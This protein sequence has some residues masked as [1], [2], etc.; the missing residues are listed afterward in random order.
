MARLRRSDCHDWPRS[1][2]QPVEG[3]V[4]AVLPLADTAAA[5]GRRRG[6]ADRAHLRALVRGARAGGRAHD[7]HLP[8]V[9]CGGHRHA[10]ARLPA[11]ARPERPVRVAA[12]PA[13]PARMAEMIAAPARSERFDQPA[14]AAPWIWIA[15]VAATLVAL[16]PSIASTAIAVAAAIALAWIDPRLPLR[17]Q[18][19]A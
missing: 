3:A 9:L 13:W 11:A 8:T 2:R 12:G 4:A 14:Q 7:A 15:V 5:R 16:G 17:A 19:T 1:L 18:W 10:A 6:V